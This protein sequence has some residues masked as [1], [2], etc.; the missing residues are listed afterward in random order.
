[1]L[2]REICGINKRP[3]FAKTQLATQAG[4]N[5]SVSVSSIV[6]VS[7]LDWVNGISGPFIFLTCGVESCAIS[8]KVKEGLLTVFQNRN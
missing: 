7:A 3:V 2:K 8:K 1:M 5:I 4:H 6:K